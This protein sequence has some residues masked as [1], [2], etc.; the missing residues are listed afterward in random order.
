MTKQEKIK[1]FTNK[2]L[3]LPILAI[4]ILAGSMMY[5]I[6][7]KYRILAVSHEKDGKEY[8]VQYTNNSTNYYLN[9]EDFINSGYAVG[10]SYTAIFNSS[11]IKVS[12]A[13]KV[14][15]IGEIL[16]SEEIEIED[17]KELEEEIGPLG[18]DEEIGN[19]NFYIFQDEQKIVATPNLDYINTNYL[20]N[21]PKATSLFLNFLDTTKKKISLKSECNREYCDDIIETFQDDVEFEKDGDS[22]Y[23]SRTNTFDFQERFVNNQK[24]R[25]TQNLI[26]PD[27]FILR[28][29]EQ[30]YDFREK[31]RL[32]TSDYMIDI[33]TAENKKRTLLLK[34]TQFYKYVNNGDKSP[35]LNQITL[36]AKNYSPII[37]LYPDEISKIEFVHPYNGYSIELD[38]DLK[39]L[40]E[41]EVNPFYGTLL[42]KNKE[43][44]NKTCTSK[45]RLKLD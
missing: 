39:K 25:I 16:T 42:L 24:P 10:R 26:I 23:L 7:N 12:T 13:T 4:S 44:K 41:I 18:K 37:Y 34:D 22:L 15:T 11:N 2:F 19:G 40:T 6:L 21:K 8:T 33:Y 1:M 32:E 5:P 45:F 36:E 3:L 29:N 14:M 17:I 30:D 35:E 38:I 43:C 20:L 31:S 9:I 27:G 28:I